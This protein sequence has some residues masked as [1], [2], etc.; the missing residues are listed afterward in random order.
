[1]APASGFALEDPAQAAQRCV[2][3]LREQVAD[4]IICLS[5]SGTNEKKSLSEDEQLAEAVEGI[6][7]IVSGHTHT[8]LTEPIV[9]GDTY[10]VSAGPYCQNLGSITLRWNAE[11]EKTLVEY[12]LIPIDETLPED[13]EI[14]ALADGWKAQVD[15]SYL[16]AYGL[17]YDHQRL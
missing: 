2:E 17:T 8:T 12:Q 7:L 14:Q 6:D 5:H 11:G 15:A 13:P 4:F 9:S 3:A 10:I 1:M 16:S